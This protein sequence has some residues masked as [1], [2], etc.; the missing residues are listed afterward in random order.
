MRRITGTVLLAFLMNTAVLPG[1]SQLRTIS[2]YSHDRINPDKTYFVFHDTDSVEFA[3]ASE[4][5]HITAQS[6][7]ESA[8]IFLWHFKDGSVA[9]SLQ[10][11]CVGDIGKNARYLLTGK[12][13]KLEDVHR[14]PIQPLTRNNYPVKVELWIG[15]VEDSTGYTLEALGDM[16]CFA[17]PSIEPNRSYH[18]S[19]CPDKEK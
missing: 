16:G 9:Y 8:A 11:E 17:E 19:A 2:E 4:W 10:S 12:S 3:W 6:N 15:K 13:S 1:F 7:L 5:T 14:K 18:F